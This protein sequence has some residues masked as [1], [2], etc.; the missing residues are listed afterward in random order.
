MPSLDTM[1]SYHRL[2]KTPLDDSMVFSNLSDLMDYCDTGACYNG[3]RVSVCDANDI[4]VEYT[5]KKYG[6]KYFPIIDT[7]G[8]ELIF[9][10]IN[11]NGEY[12]LLVYE[13]NSKPGNEFGQK[14]V[15]SFDEEKLCIISQLEIF[16][17]FNFSDNKYFEFHITR[18]Y[19]KALNN[20]TI[21]QETWTQS[22]NP[23]PYSQKDSYNGIGN[24]KGIEYIKSS[25]YNVSIKYN[26]ILNMNYYQATNQMMLMPYDGW[27]I[28]NSHENDYIT[29]IYVK[30]TDYYY[31][32]NN[33]V[34]EV[35]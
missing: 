28:S 31:A 24:T 6:E 21:E 34:L 32:L 8:S 10:D 35:S 2:M 4:T 29:K 3:Q 13:Y 11:D 26:G 5:I 25:P 9:K 16:R 19:R 12:W 27:K 18:A 23:Y 7:K 33:I 1:M 15:F 20:N 14:D 17:L 22:V 30:A